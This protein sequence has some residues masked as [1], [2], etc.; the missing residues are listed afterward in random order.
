MNWINITHECVNA[1]MRE[2]NEN[3]CFCGNLCKLKKNKGVYVFSSIIIGKKWKVCERTFI[4]IGRAKDLYVRMCQYMNQSYT[5]EGKKFSCFLDFC[6]E[7][8]GL[9]DIQ[10]VYEEKNAIGYQQLECDMVTKFK[11]VFNIIGVSKL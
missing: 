1:S 2:S 8:G 3:K 6:L 11:P 10:I 9:L 4:Y 7:K 5:P